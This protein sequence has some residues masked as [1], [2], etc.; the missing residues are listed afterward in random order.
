M[1]TSLQQAYQEG[2]CKGLRGHLFL[3]LISTPVPA[4]SVAEPSHEQ[5]PCPVLCC[6]C[7]L[8]TNPT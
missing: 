7:L 2:M 5:A 4:A 1:W 6:L 3:L 8:L